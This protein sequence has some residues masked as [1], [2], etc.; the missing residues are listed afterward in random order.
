MGRGRD[1]LGGV[2]V[3]FF[4]L[5]RSTRGGRTNRIVE[6]NIGGSIP[7]D[8]CLCVATCRATLDRSVFLFVLGR[9][10]LRDGSGGLPRAVAASSSSPSSAAASSTGT[11]LITFFP[12]SFLVYA[13][14]AGS[15]YLFCL[16][17]HPQHL[18]TFLSGDV[19]R[20]VDSVFFFSSFLCI[21]FRTDFYVCSSLCFGRT[22]FSF[23]LFFFF[24]FF[25]GTAI[26][27][28][29]PNLLAFLF[30][31][32]ILLF[33]LPF[34]RPLL[35]HFSFALGTYL[36]NDKRSVVCLLHRL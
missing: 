14:F 7:F 31:A 29:Y 12:F 6:V 24:F 19:P 10:E 23:F 8:I 36:G 15:F 13:H 4:F 5:M 28:F 27:H 20:S 25:F 22:S 33:I 32:S 2:M 1:A 16:L 34:A 30:V 18:L 11:H 26:S 9:K 3:F 35:F 21:A 17:P